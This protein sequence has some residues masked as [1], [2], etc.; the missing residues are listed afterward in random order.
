LLRGSVDRCCGQDG[1]TAIDSRWRSNAAPLARMRPPLVRAVPRG[2]L[3]KLLSRDDGQRMLLVVAPAGSGKTTLL[4]Q[5]AHAA[6]RPV[7]WYWADSSEQSS[8]LFISRLEQSLAEALP[9]LERGWESTED[10]CRGLE[11][12]HGPFPL[13]VIDDFHVLQGSPA[14]TAFENVLLSAPRLQV[15]L[16]S[17]AL[18]G[19]DLSRL[20][21]SGRLLELGPEDLRFRS[22]EV[23]H[24]FRDFYGEPLA[25]EDLALLTRR[26]EGWAAALQLFHLATRGKPPA[27]RRRTLERLSTSSK[28]MREYLARN[29]ID[30]LPQHLRDFLLQTCVLGKL[31]A[32]ICDSYLGAGNSARTLEELERRQLFTSAVNAEEEYRYH[33]VLRSH[34]EA[35]LVEELGEDDARIRYRTAG[36]LLEQ[37][38][39]LPDA[40]RAFCRAE[41]WEAV[42]GLVGREGERLA[43]G[44]PGSFEFLPATISRH[45]PW[46]LLAA[47]RQQRAAGKFRSAVETYREAEEAFGPALASDVCRRERRTLTAWLGPAPKPPSGWLGLIRQATV[48]DPRAA[49]RAASTGP[50]GAEQTLAAGIAALLAGHLEEALGILERLSCEPEASLAVGVGASVA[51]AVSRLLSGDMS[52]IRMAESSA[53]N[54]EHLGLPW[55]A[56]VSRAALALA[57]GADDRS[58]NGSARLGFD[59]EQDPFGAALATLLEGWGRLNAGRDARRELEQAADEFGHL[60]ATIL[61][62]WSRA[63]LSLALAR[64]GDPLAG[65]SAMRAQ[66]R[67]RALGVPGAQVLAG[68]A[69]AEVDSDRRLD[70]ENLARASPGACGLAILQPGSEPGSTPFAIGNGHTQSLAV[71]CFGGFSITRHG[72]PLDLRVVKPRVRQMLRLL[73]LHA[74]RPI[75]RD[76]LIEALW[77][78]TDPDAASRCLHVA[79]SSLRQLLVANGGNGR[80]L[81]AR[82]GEAYRLALPDGARVDLIEFDRA[83]ADGRAAR[84]LREIDRSVGAYQRVVDLHCGELLP[85]DGPAEWVVQERSR[86]C[87]EACAAAEAIA[88]MAIDRH[89]FEA[90]A[91]ACERGLHI[92]RYRDKL[93]RLR[94]VSCEQAG[95][96]AAALR[97]RRDYQQVIA[98]LSAP[99]VPSAT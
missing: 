24:L 99:P 15:V 29:V 8:S 70:Y 11:E 95:E 9:G 32:S 55:L 59:R 18:P 19:F 76:L 87:G 34:L 17:R 85:E 40:L 16:G 39:A 65:K 80:S 44:S 49:R 5:F 27:Q 52:G 2:R 90:A 54:A 51:T 89:D 41:D 26:T 71:R 84:A 10:L 47:A 21:V 63:A 68:C 72:I 37:S 79:I 46:L 62:E 60:G 4:V 91:A 57:H 86:R 30:E 43:N 69:L 12:W 1:P 28:P 48:S 74:G 92:D 64:S 67:A 25:P 36:N 14:E 13:L 22:W 96:L 83:F 82:D 61:E 75:H 98:E 53:D 35:M 50:P 42:R 94:V 45:D 20:R 7:A 66:A 77:P 3:T 31:S 38:G 58:Q 81:V 73:A 33:E 6:V 88:E 78:S 23:E 56:R 93:W 97:A